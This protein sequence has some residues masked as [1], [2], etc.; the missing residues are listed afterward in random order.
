MPFSIFSVHR[1]LLLAVVIQLVA[2][3]NRPASTYLLREFDTYYQHDDLRFSYQ[4]PA[5]YEPLELRKSELRDLIQ[6]Y[7]LPVRPKA[8]FTHFQTNVS[9][10]HEHFLFYLP[11]ER[12]GDE[13]FVRFR[14]TVAARSAG[15]PF[16]FQL[17]DGEALVWA[18]YAHADGGYVLTF[19]RSDA[20]NATSM[21]G[22]YE[23]ILASYHSGADYRQE[24]PT[25]PYQLAEEFLLNADSSLN[26][27]RPL[28]Q[29]EARE[30]NY[31]DS[32]RYSYV[33]AAATYH[34]FVPTEELPALL[35]EF[36]SEGSYYGQRDKIDPPVRHRGAA[37]IDY[38]LAA[39]AEERLVMFNEVHFAPHH[40]RLV[41]ELLPQLY[42]QG[43][44]YLALEA[45]WEDGETLAARGF[46]TTRSGFY[47]REPAFAELVRRAL[48]LGFQLVGYDFYTKD[49]EAEQ[50]QNL[51]ERTF[52]R[53]PDAR[54]VVLAGFG[55]I[56][57]GAPRGRPMMAQ[58]LKKNYGIDPLTIDQAE[59]SGG[60]PG[61]A[62][63]EPGAV[64]ARRL[65]GA[66]LFLLNNF[67]SKEAVRSISLPATATEKL[68][69][70]GT[71][72]M[73]NVYRTAEYRQTP[74]AIPVAN[75]RLV[76]GQRAVDLA[77]PAGD[78]LGVLR[79]HYGE[80]LAEFPVLPSR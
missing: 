42:A 32:L 14:R 69:K 37:A 3:C 79:D 78:Y 1:L 55:H 17:Q 70:L 11:P 73:L 39:T 7:E 40:R 74:R 67:Q 38:L 61:V 31:P 2:A 57:E 44:R 46:P 52:G 56:H 68:N 15:K 41:T 20:D 25:S 36:R 30:A 58:L 22:E 4:F 12:N 5:D 66:D 19:A 33:Q 49:R 8:L 6:R 77:L 50:A 43:F 35:A 80:M 62:I 23:K 54:V 24:V 76:P 34:S 64:P 29:L 47:L 51:Y 10:F 9:P 75:R 26:L 72:L 18:V 71:E 27:L 28:Q 65:I 63:V 60:E 16:A 45:L 48:D 13:A 53:D 59:F 21:L